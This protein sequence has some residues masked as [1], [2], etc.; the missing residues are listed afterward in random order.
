MGEA[1]AEK[2]ANAAR[3][4]RERSVTRVEQAAQ[5]IE[6]AI[7]EEQAALSVARWAKDPSGRRWKVA[8][9]SGEVG[10][11]GI[12][13]DR[14]VAGNAALAPWLAQQP[15]PGEE[16]EEPRIHFGWSGGTQAPPGDMRVS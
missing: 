7:A 1:E 16:V 5:E 3:Q 13:I 11:P 14:L 10:R 4:T 15:V 9:A 8:L 2:L 12:R 6:Q